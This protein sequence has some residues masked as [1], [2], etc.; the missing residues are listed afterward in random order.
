MRRLLTLAVALALAA[1]PGARADGKSGLSKADQKAVQKL[2]D[3]YVRAY[4]RGDAKALAAVFTKDATI[5]NSAGDVLKGRAAIEKGLTRAFAGPSK[6]AK[7]V[8]APLGTRA[9]AP[10]V[11]VTHGTARTTGGG[12]SQEE[13]TFAYTKV[14][15]R[16]GKQ[17]R[18]AAAQFAVPTS[19]P[20]EGR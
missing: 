4:N 16:Q 17:W 6:G 7:L 18:V 9:V 11:V 20:A 19:P 13:H 5:L 10:G 15:V 8:N 12:G 2:E 14:L 3:N 1:A